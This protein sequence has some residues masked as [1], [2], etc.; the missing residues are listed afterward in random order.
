LSDGSLILDTILPP[1]RIGGTRN[2][3]GHIGE[4]T[5]TL[6]AGRQNII[7]PSRTS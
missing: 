6:V 5:G 3:G 7:R 4:A 1:G 2:R